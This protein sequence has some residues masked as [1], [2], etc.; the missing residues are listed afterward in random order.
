[1]TTIS[2]VPFQPALEQ[3][4]T[5]QTAAAVG[6]PKLDTLKA[7]G[8]SPAVNNSVNA[9]VLGKVWV[10]LPSLEQ[11]EQLTDSSDFTDAENQKVLN[12]VEKRVGK[13]GL[14]SVL[15]FDPASWE[16]HV[17][18]LVAA[19]MA[20][21]ISRQ[22]SA[23]L[24][25]TYAV[26]AAE[27]AKAQ[28]MSIIEAGKAVMNSALTAA[29]VAGTMALGG[30]TLSLKGQSQKHADITT[31][32]RDSMDSRNRATDLQN[33]LTKKDFVANPNDTVKTFTVTDRGGKTREIA[34]DPSANTLTPQERAQLSDEITSLN[35]KAQASE[36]QSALNEKTYSKN[37]TIGQT[38]SSIAM[39]LSTMISSIVRMEEYAQRQNEVEHQSTQTIARSM[40]EE[41][42]QEVS[43]D[44]AL[45]QKLMEVF[46]Q[47]MQGRNAASSAIAGGMKV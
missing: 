42:A 29:A 14:E 8:S 16:K 36:L 24:K 34:L 11:L 43:Q 30:M 22:T 1:M 20:V 10:A 27:G 13:E 9:Q 6:I 39:V 33:D 45:M 35:K 26:M 2:S 7:M 32:K 25:G 19:I 37:I 44:N 38:M 40:T 28:G 4:T 46:M 15:K 47:I 21:N 23:G 5:E 31:N 41:Q 17:G 3:K 18:V 12:E